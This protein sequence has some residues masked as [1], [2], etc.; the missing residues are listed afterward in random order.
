LIV[1]NRLEAKKAL[2]EAAALLITHTC[3]KYL[4]KKGVKSKK[5]PALTK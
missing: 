1:L 5:R 2:K 4:L 3:K